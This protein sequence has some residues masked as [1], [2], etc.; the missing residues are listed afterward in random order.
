VAPGRFRALHIGHLRGTATVAGLDLLVSD[1]LP[2]LDRVLG[3]DGYELHLVGGYY[4]T[5]PERIRHVLNRPNVA[6][7]G[8]VFPPDPEFLNA[9]VVLVPTPIR[10]G[11]RVRIVTAL[12]FG[13]CVVAHVA[14][15]DGI[16]ELAH[17]H[18]CLIGV[19]GKSVAA[20]CIRAARD[21]EL[22]RRVAAAGRATYEECF[23]LT[24]AGGAI[25]EIL[26]RLAAKRSDLDSSRQLQRR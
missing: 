5:L 23:S 17:D 6:V 16:P 11:I 3:C 10:L 1:I 15:R 22:R 7:R 20:E 13:S 18:N 4:E 8:Q 9:H 2:E 12:S 24:T 19:D 21:P 26:L 25:E 14:N